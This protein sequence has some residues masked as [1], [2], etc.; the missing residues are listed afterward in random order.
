MT[1]V[2]WTR[3]VLGVNLM[4]VI[5]KPYQEQRTSPLITPPFF[6]RH[7]GFGDKSEHGPAAAP[8]LRGELTSDRCDTRGVTAR[9]PGD[10]RPPAH[11]AYSSRRSSRVSRREA[12]KTS[13]SA[14]C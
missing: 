7:G 8:V 12:A 14:N 9:G 5:S 2:R 11:S 3:S 13:C 4:S 1:A 10:T 6:L